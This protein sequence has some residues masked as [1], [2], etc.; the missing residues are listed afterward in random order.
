MFGRVLPGPPSIDVNV[1]FEA[2]VDQAWAYMKGT[3]FAVEEHE[4]LRTVLGEKIGQDR[5]RD[6]TG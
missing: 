5:G 6:K 3:F 1:P 2:R 4:R